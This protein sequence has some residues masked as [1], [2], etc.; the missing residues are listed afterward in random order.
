MH[1]YTPHTQTAHTQVLR[2]RLGALQAAVELTEADMESGS[3]AAID[4]LDELRVREGRASAA[5]ADG[6]AALGVHVAAINE[7]L[8]ELRC[9][10][11]D[12]V[13]MA[14]DTA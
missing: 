7:K 12:L 6:R 1:P 4:E 2:Q 3:T 11:V 14:S 10:V 5:L 9:E 8:E 13:D